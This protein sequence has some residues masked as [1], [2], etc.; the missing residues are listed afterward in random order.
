MAAPFTRILSDVH[1]GDK[2]S[3]VASLE[4]LRPLLEGPG[5]LLFNGDT[6]DTR[7]GPDP[8]AD[9]RRLEE[10]RAF[11]ASAGLPVSLLTGNHDPDISSDH[12]TEL[13]GGRVLV[14][15]GDILF[16]NIVPWSREASVLRRKVIAALAAM[17]PGA[18]ATFEGRLKAFRAVSASIPQT[19]QS[20][21]NLVLYAI[22][23]ASNTV[24]PPH[25]MMHMLQAWSQ[26]PS[27][28]ASIAARHRP[29]AAVIVIGHTHR[30]GVWRTAAGVTVVNTGSFCRPFGGIAADVS[31]AGV[32]IRR[33][34]LERGAFRIGRT[35]TEIPLS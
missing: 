30:P 22:G 19:H 33:V 25:R 17:P 16:D 29:S 34:G 5:A 13:A 27:R 15:H 21:G 8:A 12:A 14:T 2:V 23:L 3:R 6:L 31:E 35:V 32:S 7:T 11:A 9:A 18:N 26:A 1:Y 20:E 10:V 24:W 4:Q 28:A